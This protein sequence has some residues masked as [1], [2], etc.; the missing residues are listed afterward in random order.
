MQVSGFVNP[1][2]AY[3]LW[4]IACGW[5]IW[6]VISFRKARKRGGLTEEK[7]QPKSAVGGFIGRSSHV[8]VSHCHSEGRIIV[9]GKPEDINAGGLIG[10]AEDTEVVDSS[11][12][13]EIEYNQD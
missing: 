7:T 9:R 3:I 1:L 5:L 13:A 4:G 2:L 8:K 10:Q 11:A 12:N 6:A